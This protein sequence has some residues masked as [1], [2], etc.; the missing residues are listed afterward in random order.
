MNFL[1]E[2][3]KIKDQLIALRRDFHSHPELDYE[4]FRTNEKI[5]N[6]LESEGIE[7]KI[8]A[9]TG[10]CAIIK[11][12]KAGKTIGIRGDM[13]ALPLQDE[14]KCE[15]ASKTKGKMHACGH[16]VH[17]TILMG[18]AK[19]LNSMKSELNGN[20]KLFF[21]PAEE[22]T[23]GAKIM[24]HEGVLENPKVDAVIGLHVEEAINVG[25]IG[26]KKGV[27]NAASNPFT[28]K[29][30]G[31]GGHG[32][33]PNTTIDPVV[34]SCNVVNALQTII[35][36]ELP[37]TSPG[38]IT[39]GYIHGGTA[40][41]IIPEEAE[42]GGIIRTMTTEHRVYVKKRLKEITEGI[43]SSMRGSCDIEIEESYPCLYNDDEIL[44][45]VNNS[46]EEVLGKE[47]VNILENPS[48]GVES[49]AYFSLERPSAFYY[50]GCRNEERGIVNPAHGSLFDVDE[51]CIP[52]GVAIQCTAAVKMLKEL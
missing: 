32:A 43:V 13:D 8:V 33:R 21:E 27:V 3:N 7:Y 44:K 35:S 22:T 15:Y 46:A 16:D 20:I 18:V 51:D 30:K 34:I 41:N 6:F 17:T 24:I 12:A 29:I 19:L 40:Q 45:V 47:K 52:I 26:L 37:P 50:L 10:I 48:M 23:G 11:G 42:I 14:K 38:V 28:I 39:V 2:A 31:K 25:E 5:K 9:K 49:F 1:N 4:L 36:R